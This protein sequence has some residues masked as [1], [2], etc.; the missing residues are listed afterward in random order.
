MASS[1]R[2]PGG[3]LSARLFPTS[4]GF[5]QHAHEHRPERPVLLEADQELGEGATLRVAPEL[6]DPVVDLSPGFCP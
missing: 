3:R 1:S 2:R 4:V 6:A 5:P